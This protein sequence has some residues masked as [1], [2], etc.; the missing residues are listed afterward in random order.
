MSRTE[1]VSSSMVASFSSAFNFLLTRNSEIAQIINLGY[2]SSILHL[3]TLES[4]QSPPYDETTRTWN[5]R[6]LICDSCL[7]QTSAKIAAR[8]EY[9]IYCLY[10]S[11]SA[12]QIII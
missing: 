9:I 8:L 3:N 5:V 11:Y 6:L 12:Q 2:S 1:V 7:L 10:R 4:L